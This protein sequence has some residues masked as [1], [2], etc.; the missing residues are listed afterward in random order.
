MNDSVL[1]IAERHSQAAALFSLA[2]LEDARKRAHTLLV[3]LM[4]GGS[5]LAGV[6]LARWADTPALAVAA[7]AGAA[8][9]FALA[10]YVAWRGNTTAEVRAWAT[11]DVLAVHKKWGVYVREAQAEAAARGEP[12]PASAE[13]ELRCELLRNCDLAGAGYRAASLAAFAV[14]DTAYR[15]AALAPVIAVAAAAC[16][17]AGGACLVA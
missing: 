8:W 2:G 1:E 9:W 7:L 16:W 10:A 5:G 15:L 6:G 14:L 12:D 11:P 4:A 17:A 3:L 13:T